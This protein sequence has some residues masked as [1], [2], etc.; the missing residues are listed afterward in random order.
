MN[1]H[2]YFS[3]ESY[4]GNVEYLFFLYWPPC[5]NL[6]SS[7]TICNC[8]DNLKVYTKV[9]FQ[10]WCATQKF[11]GAQSFRLS[12]LKYCVLHYLWTFLHF[13][14]VSSM[15]FQLKFWH[16]KGW[17]ERVTKLM[18]VGMNGGQC[19]QLSKRCKIG[20]YKLVTS[21]PICFSFCQTL[22]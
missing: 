9:N 15:T 8:F 14:K 13:T 12:S 5:L 17:R 3:T 19:W 7:G 11:W 4:L 16:S 21:I 18:C 6:R 20:C 2:V 1:G 10:L 22:T